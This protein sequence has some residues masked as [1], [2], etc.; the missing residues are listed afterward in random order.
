[1]KR[2]Y[3]IL[4]LMALIGVFTLGGFIGFLFATGR[5]NAQRIDQ[6]AMVLRGES[7]QQAVAA[8]R[9][10]TQP[11]PP[12]PQPSRAEI[13]RLQA[14][15]EYFEL[16]G[17]RLKAEAEQR[18]M[19]NE[20]IRLDLTRQLEENQTRRQ[21]TP[22]EKKR[23][24]ARPANPEEETG[25]DKELEIFGSMDPKLA[26]D[27]LMKRKEPDAIQ[28][29]MRLEPVRVK[30]IVDACKTEDE[31]NW[32]GRILNQIHNMDSETANGVDGPNA[33]SR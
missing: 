23:P 8:S 13:A 33:S 28:L 12:A 11:T 22:E 26:R 32:I 17:E 1:M 24:L 3:H 31:R 18:R 25:L 4:C 27:L 30:K 20:R 15:K 19:L 21:E 29:L 5:L 14:Q 9:P 7:P 16:A 2:L 6:I 10:A